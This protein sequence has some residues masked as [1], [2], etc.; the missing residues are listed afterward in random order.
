[1]RA[2][3]RRVFVAMPLLVVTSGCAESARQPAAG[4]AQVQTRRTIGKT[5]QNVLDLAVAQAQGGVVVDNAAE[6]EEG[7][8]GAASQAYRHGVA[9]IGGLAVEHKMRLHQAEHGAVPATHQE[10]MAQ[11]IAPGAPDGVSLPML[12]YYQEY[13]FDPATRKLVVVEFPAKKAQ[14]EKETAGSAGL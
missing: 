9:A 4:S 7:G 11:I 3:R 14:R 13:A 8:L 1:M 2:W 6:V 5:T 12:P 10:F